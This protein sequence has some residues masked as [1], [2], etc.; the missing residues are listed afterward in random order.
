MAT[1]KATVEGAVEVGEVAAA[2]DLG[3]RRQS[4]ERGAAQNPVILTCKVM[5]W[6]TASG[7]PH[8]SQGSFISGGRFFPGDR[9]VDLS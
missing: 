5:A 4:E 8:L 2:V 1:G 7:G 3:S 6:T 9:W